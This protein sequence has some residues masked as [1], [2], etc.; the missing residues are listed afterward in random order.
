[1][2]FALVGA[3]ASQRNF[4]TNTDI[5]NYYVNAATGDDTI[6]NGLSAAAPFKTGTKAASLATTG[7]VVSMAS[8][9]YRETITPASGVTFRN[10]PGAVVLISGLEVISNTG[11]VVDSGQIYRKALTL[12]VNGYGPGGI[13]TNT[14]ILAN[15]IFRDGEMMIEARWPKGVQSQNDLF[16][17]DANGTTGPRRHV[18]QMV[19]SV[20]NP[21]G[22]TDSG[23]TVGQGFPLAAGQ[24]VGAQLIW[25][26]WFVSGSVTINSHSAGG[27]VSHAAIWDTSPPQA[28]IQIRKY[29]YLTGKREFLTQQREF[30]YNGT[31]LYFWQPGGGAPTG[32]IEYKARNWGFNLA[33]KTG[34]TIKG[35]QFIGCEPAYGN[36]STT[37][38]LLTDCKASYMN[39]HITFPIYLFQGHGMTQYMG[40]GMKGTGNIVKNCEFSWAA[41]GAIWLGANGRVENNL[42]HHIGYAGAWG[43]PVSYFGSDNISNCVITKNTMYTLG[44]GGVDNGYAFIEGQVKNTTNN[45]MS[46]NNI[47]DFN[48]LNQDGGAFYSW[49]YQNLAG[50]KFHHNWIH[51]LGATRP[52]DSTPTDGIMAA[53]YFDMGSGPT[54]GQTPNSVHHNC[55]WNMGNV[56]NHGTWVDT[57]IGDVYTQP[58]FSYSTKGPT[59][60]HNNTFYGNQKAYVTYQN[61]TIDE[62]RN[63][64]SRGDLNFNWGA[65]G[66]NVANAVL[67]GTNP[68]F[69]GGDLA[70]LQGLYFRLAPTSPARNAGTI[71]AGI[72][73]GFLETAP[74]IG[75]YEYGDPSPWTAGY[76][77][78]PVDTGGGGGGGGSSTI[79]AT[80]NGG[81][82]A[83][84][85]TV[86]FN[87]P[88]GTGGGTVGL[89]AT[90]A[91]TFSDGSVG[92]IGINWLTGS[93]NATGSPYVDAPYIVTGTPILTGLQTDPGNLSITCT[94]TVRHMFFQVTSTILGLFDAKGL[95]ANTNN[96]FGTVDASSNCTVWKSIAPGPLGRDFNS[97]GVAPKISGGKLQFIGTGYYE[98]AAAISAI[99]NPLFYNAV[100]ANLK[101]T[102]VIVGRVNDTNTLKSILGNNGFSGAANGLA[103]ITETSAGNGN[104]AINISGGA[105]DVFNWFNVNVLGVD[106][107]NVYTFRLDGSLA[108]GS[109]KGVA[110]RGLTQFA[111]TSTGSNVPNQPPT[112]KMTIGNMGTGNNVY[113][114]IGNLSAIYLIAGVET[115]TITNKLITDA[116]AVFGVS[117]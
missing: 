111:A 114:H 100:A 7:Q 61:G 14:D 106:V 65:A 68:Q 67:K 57:E 31:N 90:V 45:E 63:N 23:L 76:N 27:A 21:T 115:P 13:A 22:F 116:G 99:W 110:N 29:Y 40:T 102:I 84:P 24:L 12:P 41:A 53:I 10:A 38:S 79:L 92:T 91:C 20:W 113:S 85:I 6:N 82:N 17:L 5:A 48:K 89:P 11:W 8:G 3:V 69:Q 51:D 18:S 97:I 44:R 35:I 25:T 32:V 60:Y 46:Y 88:F 49:G 1:M 75:C 80:I 108:A 54:V 107:D 94:I 73:D 105:G 42:F 43:V 101:C 87:T 104:F 96:S 15:Q 50:C 74:D 71:I 103:V 66:S 34:V 77:T 55:V 19:G 37:N 4:I 28:G 47:Y 86:Q 58:S 59:K 83:S 62:F 93:Y 81:V 112:N 98:E 26:G 117:V 30:F 39:H 72:T 64:I 95:I 33:N 36:A 2:N 9:L 70:T 16:T 52:P 78:V 56:S 109:G